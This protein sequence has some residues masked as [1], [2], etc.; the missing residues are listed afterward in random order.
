MEEQRATPV[1]EKEIDLIE[2]ARNLWKRKLFIIKV[3]GIFACLGIVVALLS[4]VEYTAKCTMVPQTGEKNV[5]GGLSGLAAMAG[6]NMGSL[7]GGEI[8]SPKIYPV[9]LSSI[10][11]QKDL[12]KTPLTFSTIKEPVALL[13]YYT[14]PGCQRKSILGEIK[15]YTIGLPGVIIQLI[16]GE[17]GD[18]S[19]S[20]G[21]NTIQYF[22]KEEKQCSDILTQVLNLSVDSKDGSITLSAIMPEALPAAQLAQQAQILLQEYITR[23]KIQKVQS[24]LDFV[25]QRY[26]EVKHDF[27]SKQEEYA[28][29]RDKNKNLSLATA[30]I[31]EEKLRNEYSLS[32]SI[33]TELA[34]Q[35]EQAKIAVK[36]TTPI[37]TVIDPVLLPT[38]RSKPKRGMICIMFTFLG[39][40]LGCGLVFIL[41][42]IAGASGGRYLKNWLPEQK[43]EDKI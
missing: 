36:E 24:N 17:K 14:K 22:T 37:L 7:S 41:P 21:T 32:L 11:F 19:M 3:S 13:D 29:F 42:F 30:S 20:L 2:L 9:I 33:Y 40:F 25:Q 34:K 8:L 1:Q 12:M 26:D 16:R 15:K 23:F 43:T 39:G 18:K 5:S 10:P 4:S 6:I 28:S 27:E 35:L 31:R 38:D